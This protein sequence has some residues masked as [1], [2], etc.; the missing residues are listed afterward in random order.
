MSSHGD[1]QSC[2]VVTCLLEIPPFPD[3]AE[4]NILYVNNL[5]DS[6]EPEA[7]WCADCQKQGDGRLSAASGRSRKLLRIS[8]EN[9]P[10]SATLK[11]EGKLAGPWID[12]VVRTW[13]DVVGDRPA[14]D[15]TV[16]L[17]GVMFIDG[18]GKKLLRWMLQRGARLREGRLMTKYIVDQV[19]EEAGQLQHQQGGR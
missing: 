3:P 18:D 4:V 2:S 11:L 16:D 10:Q 5:D 19:V 8:Y 15:V 7:D 9:N 14:K 6:P 1:M 12:E 17:S 13:S